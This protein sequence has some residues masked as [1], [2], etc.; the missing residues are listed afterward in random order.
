MVFL[1]RGH[2]IDAHCQT[3]GIDLRRQCD[4][5]KPTRFGYRAQCQEDVFHNHIR[6]DPGVSL[7]EHEILVPQPNLDSDEETLQQQPLAEQGANRLG[8]RQVVYND[9]RPAWQEDG[10]VPMP[11]QSSQLDRRSSSK[12][13]HQQ[14]APWHLVAM[15]EEPHPDQGPVPERGLYQ[16]P[17]GGE[18]VDAYVIDDGIDIEHE[19]FGGRAIHYPEM[20]DKAVY[21]KTGRLESRYCGNMKGNEG[22]KSLHTGGRHGTQVAGVLG[23]K[24]Y[25]VAK[26]VT[27][28]NVKYHCGSMSSR[29]GGFVDMLYDILATH[30]DKKDNPDEFRSFRG[31][32][33]QLSIGAPGRSAAMR[34]AGVNLQH[35]GIWITYA[36]ENEDKKNEELNCVDDAWI[37]VTSFD[38]YYRRPD[39][40][41]YGF[42]VPF[43]APGKD[44]ESPASQFAT[45]K[46][47][48]KATSSGNSFAAPILAGLI[49]QIQTEYKLK[50]KASQVRSKLKG[51]SYSNILTKKRG[52]GSMFSAPR[53]AHNAVGRQK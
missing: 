45:G 16:Y 23:S 47:N 22:A 11:S 9:T 24:T 15:S 48:D 3:I 46:K 49:A 12:M 33:I 7:V 18:G 41:A 28:L 32:V 6:R 50:G 34:S 8:K 42:N 53:M 25:G 1:R 52:F 2:S 29:S 19:E 37:C 14:D 5:F 13:P 30:E 35:S 43:G 21:E 38:R 17:N 26:G 4:W 36:A 27:I 44:I 39:A 40:R 31:S 10:F 20:I 51:N